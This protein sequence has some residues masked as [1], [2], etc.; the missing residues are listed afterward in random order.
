MERTIVDNLIIVQ[1]PGGI[2]RL[3]LRPCPAKSPG[4]G[5]IRLR[6]EAIGVNFLD[7]YHRTGDHALPMPAVLGV[8][9]AGVVEAL[10]EGV[11]S[12]QP[13]DR[14][15][16]AGAPVGAYASTRLLPAKRAIRLPDDIPARVAAAGMVK[17]LTV[18]MLVNRVYPVVAGTVVLVHAAAGGLGTV[19]TRWLKM[20]DAIVIGTTSSAEKAATARRN[21]VDHVI[22]GR[23]TDLAAEVG[24]LT[25]GKGVDYAIDGIGGTTL[26]KTL[27]SVRKFGTVASIGQAGG[28]ILPIPIEALGPARALT[29]CRPSVMAYS[30]EPET[31]ARAAAD[32]LAMMK[33]GIAADI[34]GEYSLDD[35]AKAHA[36]LESG[37]SVGSLVLV[38]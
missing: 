26:A 25:D 37:Q 32:V 35:A 3:E 12:L 20:L 28:P 38:P 34:G 17:G 33:L 24:R 6:Q 10:G 27:A 13:G 4:V 29:L 2:D 15:V 21:G 18:H 5:E 22:V 36:A 31:Y 11:G 30:A 23:D 19:L 7:I 8:E 9:G 1:E 14:V 16:Y